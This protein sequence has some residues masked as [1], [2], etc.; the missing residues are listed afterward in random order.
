[1]FDCGQPTHVFDL[2]KIRGKV[3]VREAKKGERMTTLDNK[4]VTLEES[5]MVIADDVGVLALAGIKGGKRAEVD[6][7]TKNILLEVGNFFPVRVRKTAR[8]LGIFTDAAKRFENNLSPEL[9][10]FAHRELAGLL[11]EYGFT[12]FEDIVDE[13]SCDDFK[14]KRVL[15]FSLSKISKLLGREVYVQEI[16][17][18]LQQYNMTYTEKG[19]EFKVTVPPLRLDLEIEEDMAEEVARIL[20]YDA[21]SPKAPHMAFTPRLNQ[22]YAHIVWARNKLLN[23]GYSEVMTYSFA[24]TGEVEVLASASDKRF[25]RT[26]IKAGL[27][28]SI[29]LNQ[30][31]LPLLSGKEVK[32]FEIGTVFHK[33][34]EIVHVCYGDKKHIT[35]M[36]L[37]EF[38]NSASPAAPVQSLLHG[39]LPQKEVS[40]QF[41]MW[42]LFP[43]I[44][45]DIALWVPESVSGSDVADIIREHMGTLV[46]KGPELFDTF[47]KEGRTSYA[48][49]LVFQSFNRTL[50]DEEVG[51]VMENIHTALRS[52]TGWELR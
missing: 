24:K 16:F 25:L 13:Y 14:K 28:E 31:N 29:K 45:R 5:D 52:N 32:V 18:I 20:G 11:M 33:D 51:E 26:N 7:N 48:F 43:F 15:V 35:E 8:R 22:T 2:D 49:H 38:C 19:G 36:P 1:M 40:N 42:S 17:D 4:E 27:A 12:Q 46:I 9:C 34:K 23:E 6:V 37:E 3:V 10:D 50:T 47:T 39:Q 41:K 21:I 30:L 44:A